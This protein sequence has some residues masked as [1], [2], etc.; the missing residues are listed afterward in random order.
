MLQRLQ[1]VWLF[2][3]T[4]FNAVTFRFPFYSGDWMKDSTPYVIDLNALTTTWLTI[5]TVLTAA[6][7]FITIFLFDNRKLQLKLCYL[8]IFITAVLI[9][10]YFLEIGNFYTGTVA[11]W[12]VF[13][14]AI[15]CCFILAARGV[16]KDEKLVKSMDRLR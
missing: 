11:I 2:L 6:L 13:Y 15:L 1:S 8:G 4:I 10:M 7:A 14:F 16:W 9:T 5:L 12:A 3:A